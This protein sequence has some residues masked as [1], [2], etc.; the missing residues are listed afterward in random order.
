MWP[1]TFNLN[2]TLCLS[3]FLHNHTTSTDQQHG[4]HLGLIVNTCSEVLAELFLFVRV[5]SAPSR[6]LKSHLIS[7]TTKSG[8]R[9]SPD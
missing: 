1:K 3:S 7:G 8:N 9:D 2:S 4:A 6:P 5:H